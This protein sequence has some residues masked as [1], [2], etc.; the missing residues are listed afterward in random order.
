MADL[1]PDGQAEYRAN[2]SDRH[3]RLG[4][5]VLRDFVRDGGVRHDQLLMHLAQQ[6]PQLGH[7]FPRAR[8]E[9]ARLQR[10]ELFRGPEPRGLDDALP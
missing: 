8:A 5:G 7:R 4:H 1:R 6:R 2:A 9:R 3:Q 10:R